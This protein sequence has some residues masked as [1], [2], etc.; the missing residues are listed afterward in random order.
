MRYRTTLRLW[1]FVYLLLLYNI[2]IIFWLNLLND[3]WFYFLTCV[4]YTWLKTK[5]TMNDYSES[6]EWPAY[7]WLV[8]S[9]GRALHRYRRGSGFTSRP[10]LNFFR[11]SF[12][13]CLSSILYCNNHSYLHLQFNLLS[14]TH[15][16]SSFTQQKEIQEKPVHSTVYECLHNERYSV[17]LTAALSRAI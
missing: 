15:F 6:T 12:H 11:L 13:Y 8:S 1:D 16:I 7:S 14:F 4:T 5:N 2:S 9:V 17:Y 3:W 10:R